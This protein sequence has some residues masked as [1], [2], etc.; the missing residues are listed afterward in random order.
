M[1]A[2]GV[3]WSLVAS[4]SSWVRLWKNVDLVLYN[5]CSQ[6]SNLF[7]WTLLN[8]LASWW[9]ACFL[10]IL[11][12]CFGFNSCDA[13]TRIASRSSALHPAPSSLETN[14]WSLQSTLER[15]RKRTRTPVYFILF[16]GY[17]LWRS[18]DIAPPYDPLSHQTCSQE[19]FQSYR[20]LGVTVFI[21]LTALGV[22]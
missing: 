12:G 11:P 2:G 21:R 22:Y 13:P 1:C 19:F 5:S 15:A 9:S 17:P 7:I 10:H 3:N 18:V 20:L 4:Q 14:V 8:Y 16:F 6:T